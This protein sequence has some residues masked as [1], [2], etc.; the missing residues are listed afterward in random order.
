MN[1]L[2]ALEGCGQSPWLDDLHRDLVRKGELERL[3]REDGLK[4]LTS[5]PSIFEKGIGETDEYKD[6]LEELLGEGKLDDMRVYESLAAEDIQGATDLFRPVYEASG[7][8]DG[9]V[10]LEVS[11]TL[12][13]KTAETA[14]DAER[15]WTMIGRENLMVKIPGTKAGIPAIRKTIA[16]GINVNVTL[17][18]SIDEYAAVVDA[19]M[20]GLEDLVKTGRDPSRIASVASFFLS[21]ID[22]AVE[23]KLEGKPDAD[24]ALVAQVTDKVAIACAKL[25]Y[26]KYEELYASPRWKALAAKGAKPQRLLWASTGTKKKSLPPTYYVDA[27]VG[28]DTVNTMPP[29]TLKAFREQGK[30]SKDAI[31]ADLDGA[32][33]TLDALNKLGLSLDGITD[34]LVEDGVKKFVEAFDKLL[35]GV[36]KRRRELAPHRDQS[37]PSLKAKTA[38]A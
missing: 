25:A 10:S 8:N 11:P 26:A 38:V 23:K 15:L 29:A 30:A 33:A 12:A 3:I 22:T 14:A 9:F 17:L 28:A 2:K 16:A 34:E 32:R 27:L 31:K 35:G 36:A 18:F 13:S 20:S 37:E 7:R 21:R 1:P 5:N 6:K 4:G 19:Y 24:K